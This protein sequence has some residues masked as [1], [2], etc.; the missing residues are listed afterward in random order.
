MQITQIRLRVVVENKRHA[1]SWREDRENSEYRAE[2]TVFGRLLRL[3]GTHHT[4]SIL[5]K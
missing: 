5:L 3:L 2:G 4:V 1:Q